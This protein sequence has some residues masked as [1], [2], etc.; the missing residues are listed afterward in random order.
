M[1]LPSYLFWI[2]LA[3]TLTFAVPP[4]ERLDPVNDQ[5][6]FYPQAMMIA[7][8]PRPLIFY[9]DTK[10]VHLRVNLPAIKLTKIS[11]H[12][13]PC[14]T[15]DLFPDVADYLLQRLQELETLIQRLGSL[16]GLTNLIQCDL[17]L[18][19]YFNAE[20]NLKPKMNCPLAFNASLAHC[21]AWALERCD[22]ISPHEETWLKG[23]ARRRRS[24]NI[25]CHAGLFG[26][27]RA[28]YEATGGDCEPNKV[29]NL[30]STLNK[31]ADAMEDLQSL[32]RVVNGKTVYLIKV[33]GALRT[34]LNQHGKNIHTIHKT[35]QAWKYIIEKQIRTLSC[36]VN[37]DKPLFI[38]LVAQIHKIFA[39]LIRFLENDDII[40]QLFH[41]KDLKIFGYTALPQ[42]LAKE[43]SQQLSS[44]SNMKNTELAL[45]SGFS[46]LINPMIDYVYTDKGLHVNIL[47][48]LPE[49]GAQHSMC[50][51]EYLEPVVYNIS[52]QCY[53][54]PI[55]QDNLALITCADSRSIVRVDTLA[56]CFQDNHNFVC[57]SQVLRQVTSVDW[58][59]LPW[60]RYT[61]LPFA[62]THQK[63]D[64]CS[65]L[66]PLLHLGGRY[67][68]STTSTK[69]TFQNTT[70]ELTLQL[71]PL[72]I[73]NF[74]CT[75]KLPE[76]GIDDCPEHLELH[77]PIMTV[78]NFKYHQWKPGSDKTLIDLH[79]KSITTLPPLK[80]NKTILENLDKTYNLLDAR[81][82]R[83]LS[84]IRESIA[85]IKATWE[86]TTT[87]I[88]VYIALPLSLL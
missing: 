18:K 55:D 27:P 79:L 53:S 82:T 22:H 71:S 87:E 83:R 48:T 4:F 12:V 33:T 67:Y 30:K 78:E 39:Q 9:N 76:A 36:R 41:L 24:T 80:F 62:R 73:Y 88:L 56:K 44:D 50:A 21:K 72:I 69:M 2:F 40:H 38:T 37:Q 45:K 85:K 29:S 51:V 20:T 46:L 68:L 63:I 31:M 75:V 86:T 81:L 7:R 1:Q 60:N 6:R 14:F 26:I 54:G 11:S 66:Y 49:I 25:L 65:S 28:I 3:G 34:R 42:I 15:N 64:D 74:P 16:E 84:S 61:K 23:K 17:Y 52:G 77:V 10:I 57:P 58:L 8:K 13:K 32:V 43:I 47:L 5:I 35:L 59:G 19:R 70:N